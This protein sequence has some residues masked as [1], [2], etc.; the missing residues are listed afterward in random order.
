MSYVLDALKKSEQ[1]RG[2]G[3]MLAPT[4]SAGTLA[5]PLN[6]RWWPII[7]SVL[8]VVV[9]LLVLMRFWAHDG[10][11]AKPVA[12]QASAKTIKSRTTVAGGV[13]LSELSRVDRLDVHDL[14]EQVRIGS[15]KRKTKSVSKP[16]SPK[17]TPEVATTA[18]AAVEPTMDDFTQE[19]VPEV[20]PA[21]IPFLRQMPDAF[22]EG[23]PDMV[24]NV[25][26]YSANEAENLVYINDRHIR[27]GDRIEGGVKLEAIVHDGVVLDHGGTKFKLPR[28]N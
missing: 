23:V 12:A 9:A 27:K 13:E 25:H 19:E 11:P 7:L 5:A 4:N 3:E 17:A 21:D 15:G 10:V 6:R 20:N 8:L 22:R 18:V 28:P 1:E 26:L 24:V 16:K 2:V 14:A